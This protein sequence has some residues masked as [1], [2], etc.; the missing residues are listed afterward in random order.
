M[1]SMCYRQ[2]RGVVYRAWMFP[3]CGERKL[4]ALLAVGF[5]SKQLK[6]NIRGYKF[7]IKLQLFATSGVHKT[8]RVHNEKTEKMLPFLIL[9]FLNPLI[10]AA[11]GEHCISRSM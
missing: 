10:S 6:F 3:L 11:Q 8:G 9:L 5:N 7:N 4:T 2:S 1:K